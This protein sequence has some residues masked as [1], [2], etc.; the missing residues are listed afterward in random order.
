MGLEIQGYGTLE[1]QEYRDRGIRGFRDT[2]ITWLRGYSDVEGLGGLKY[3][4]I[5]V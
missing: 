4:K 1:I 5:G 3:M 2:G